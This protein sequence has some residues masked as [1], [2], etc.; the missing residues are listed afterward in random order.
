MK[1]LKFR[2]ALTVSAVLVPLVPLIVATAAPAQA[3]SGS[4]I[5]AQ[6][7]TRDGKTVYRAIEQTYGNDNRDK[8]CFERSMSNLLKQG[9]ANP[10]P[11]GD[12]P[13]WGTCEDFRDV[14]LQRPGTADPCLSMPRWEP[15]EDRADHIREFSRP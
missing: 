6:W 11:G 13:W 8:Y 15:L 14:V 2:R 5:C 7:G 10:Q 1:T 4:R 12:R 3:Q 9:L